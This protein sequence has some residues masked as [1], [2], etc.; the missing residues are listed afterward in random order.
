MH[1][2]D[3]C[4]TYIRRLDTTVKQYLAYCWKSEYTASASKFDDIVKQTIHDIKVSGEI[5]NLKRVKRQ[6][7]DNH[8]ADAYNKKYAK[9][10]DT[11][12]N[13]TDIIDDRGNPTV[14]RDSK[15]NYINFIT[16]LFVWR[17]N[18]NGAKVF[19]TCPSIKNIEDKTAITFMI[20]LLP[21]F[22]KRVINA[23]DKL[24]ALYLFGRQGSGKSTM[25]NNCKYIKK[26]ATDSVGVGRYKMS[27]YHSALLFDDIENN[28]IE[29]VTNSSTIKQL[30]LGDSA[31]VKIF[32]ETQDINAFIIITSN[33]KP[34]F[35]VIEDTDDINT[36][37]I[38]NSWKRRFMTCLFSD[39]CPMELES[40]NY[41]DYQLRDIA[42]M[43]FKFEYE[44][45][46]KVLGINHTIL[47]HMKIYYNIA[48]TD[49]YNN[50][51][52]EEMFK[53]C[54]LLAIDKYNELIVDLEDVDHSIKNKYVQ[55]CESFD[56][57]KNSNTN[58]LEIEEHI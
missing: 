28:V 25:F 2:V 3:E 47:N 20:S 38:K 13:D 56:Y 41:N 43:F 8:G 53:S 9:I 1:E 21:Y 37:I 4:I 18:I 30:C 12:I 15:S 58:E 42:A 24:P 31:T 57:Y 17:A 14:D 6:L 54:Y 39:V 34:N 48:C 55:L 16:S 33:E 19:S 49:Y 22:T 32:G 23:S 27:N 46:I 35:C 29:D 36:K 44:K 10:A 45:L 5:P 40:V 52:D 51:T 50:S 26:V 11:Y 7:I